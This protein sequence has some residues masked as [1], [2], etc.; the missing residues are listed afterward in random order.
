VLFLQNTSGSRILRQQTKEQILKPTSVQ[1]AAVALEAM[2][3][4]RDNAPDE[5]DALMK[6][7]SGVLL[8]KAWDA[9][10]ECRHG[11]LE[12]AAEEVVIMSQYR[13]VR[14]MSSEARK[15]FVSILSKVICPESSP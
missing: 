3:H 14:S 9:L 13:G 2:R 10:K 6:T 12:Q 11:D 8:T 5:W 1:A 4:A 7:E 15:E